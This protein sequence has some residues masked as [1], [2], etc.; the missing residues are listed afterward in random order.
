MKIEIIEVKNKNYSDIELFS[1]NN[2]ADKIDLSD[3]K[4]LEVI[5]KIDTI[6]YTLYLPYSKKCKSFNYVTV[7][8]VGQLPYIF[9]GIKPK[10]QN[11]QI[12]SIPNYYANYDLNTEEKIKYEWLQKNKIPVSSKKESGNCKSVDDNCGAIIL[13]NL[14]SQSEEQLI[15]HELFKVHYYDKNITIGTVV[16][17]N[18]ED[19]KNTVTSLS[20]AAKTF[21]CSIILKP[22]IN[23]KN[24]QYN[25]SWALSKSDYIEIKAFWER[26]GKYRE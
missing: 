10:G 15:L 11:M 2:I 17:E 1:S 3:L 8:K 24:T 23:S 7:K 25:V 6:E 21:N 16:S 12:V 22:N 14:R 20:F 13:Y 9:A 4:I 19:V 26:I 18:L 5:V